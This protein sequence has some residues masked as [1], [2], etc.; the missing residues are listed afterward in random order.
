MSVKDASKLPSQ[1]LLQLLLIM[2]T[3]T[4]NLLRKVGLLEG[5][6][7][8]VLLFIAMPLKYVWQQPGAVKIVGWIHGVLF[9]LFVLLLLRVYDQKSW[10]FKKVI[11]GFVAA[12]L[13]FGTFIFDRQLKKEA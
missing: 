11:I 2:Q 10:P 1:H 13:P 9:V 7:L 12:F 5:V 4:L 8:L 3:N 6:S